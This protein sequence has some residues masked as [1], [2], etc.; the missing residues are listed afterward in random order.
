VAYV[1]QEGD[2]PRSR[3]EF[4]RRYFIKT[5]SVAV[6]GSYAAFLAACSSGGE[7]AATTTSSGPAPRPPTVPTGTLQFATSAEPRTLNPAVAVD[8]SDWGVLI[9]NIFDPLMVLGADGA[10][11][12]P[13]LATDFDS[14]PDARQWTFRL[15]DDVRFHDGRRFDSRAARDSLAYYSDGTPWVFALPVK[16]TAQFVAPDPTTLRVICDDPYPDFA[17]NQGSIA[18]LSPDQLADRGRTIAREPI[19]TGPLRFVSY[20]RGQVLEFGANDDYWGEGP[21]SE[22]VNGRILANASTRLSALRAGGI[23]LQTLIAPNQAET[24]AADPNVVIGARDGIKTTQLCLTNAKPPFD[25]LRARQAVAYAI[26]RPALIE[27]ILRDEATLTN[28][29]MP[30][31]LY[32]T[33]EPETTYAYD[34]DRARDLLQE[35]GVS[36][37]KVRLTMAAGLVNG[38]EELIQAI[39]GQLGEVGM[40]V[41]ARPVEVAVQAE[42]LAGP[43]SESPEMQLVDFSTV[44]G[45]PFL[46]T[47]G[48]SATF[49]KYEDKTYL[50]LVDELNTTPDGDKRLS[51]VAELTELVAEQVP[52]FPIC[53]PNDIDAFRN[54]VYGFDA[55]AR[56]NQVILGTAYTAT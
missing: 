36:G 54:N 1:I 33:S 21:Y 34:P 56:T 50:G 39:A 25:D 28:T 29:I 2:V 48:G 44:N 51:I 26:D 30:P 41:D 27:G 47:S 40:E 6:V 45:G 53:I 14:S 10:S 23:Q 35:A 37:S 15:R 4:N 24:L 17:R 55:E 38:G 5:G 52:F 43:L 9:R 22:S 46:F 18:M 31:G 20:N 12:E 32:G 8:L 11:I 3:H 19:G 42:E 49:S 13:W 16:G 7:N